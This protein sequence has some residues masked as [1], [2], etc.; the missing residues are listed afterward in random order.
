MCCLLQFVGS[1]LGGKNKTVNLLPA[2][3]GTGLDWIVMALGPRRGDEKK[4]QQELG[5]TMEGS[6]PWTFRKRTIQQ[7]TFHVKLESPTR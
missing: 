5:I 2:A 3:F 1:E 7:R 4:K 6:I